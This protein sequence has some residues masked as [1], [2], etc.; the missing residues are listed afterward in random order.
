MRLFKLIVPILISIILIVFDARFSYLDN[1]KRFT[2]TLLSPVYFVVD[3]PS[4]VVDWVNDQGS[5][6]AQLVSE[7]EYLEGKLIELKARLQIQNNLVLENQ[8]LTQL[9]DATYTIPEHQITLAHI[10][11]VSQS[12]L[13]KQVI[14][15]KGS[16]DSVRNTQLAVGSDGV[17]GQ[18][19]QVTPLYST[20]RLITDPTQHM[21][22]KNV[23]NGIRGITKGLATNERG[24]V[25]E[26]I[27]LDSDVK[28]GDIFVTSGIGTTYPP[29]YL[30]GKVSSID[31]PPNEA[32]LTILLKPIQNMDKLEF[33]LIVS[34]KND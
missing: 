27:P 17:I 7:N 18:V 13:K 9:L 23:R 3:L 34:Q 31:K 29:G 6:T 22:V 8:K 2:L 15:N 10:K 16:K 24:M 4:H 12:R 14:I 26:F 30:V 19:T 11:S 28:L 25:V 21:P 5:D 32:F 33:V 1:F 20:I